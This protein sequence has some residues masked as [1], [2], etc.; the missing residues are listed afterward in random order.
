MSSVKRLLAEYP[1][2][3]PVAPNGL[4]ENPRTM[5]ACALK[6][7]QLRARDLSSVTGSPF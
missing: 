2:L 3:R 5:R 4:Q 7:T 6:G 1:F